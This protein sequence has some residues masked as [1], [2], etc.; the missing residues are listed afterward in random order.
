MLIAPTFVYE[1][2]INKIRICLME[3]IGFRT[4]H[5][6]QSDEY[7]EFVCKKSFDL[8][9]SYIIEGEMLSECIL[10]RKT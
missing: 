5:Q 7:V 9:D 6:W 4:F 10:I 2:K 8:I 1:G 3:M